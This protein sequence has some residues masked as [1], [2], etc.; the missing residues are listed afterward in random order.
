MFDHDRCCAERVNS[1]C[2]TVAVGLLEIATLE[3]LVIVCSFDP[4][5][6]ARLFVHIICHKFV[7]VDDIK[8][9]YFQSILIYFV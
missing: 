3:T 9:T 1:M 8:W 2:S 4:F 7:K 5:P 6:G